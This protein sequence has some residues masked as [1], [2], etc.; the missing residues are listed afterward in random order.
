MLLI[1]FLYLTCLK[2]DKYSSILFIHFAKCEHFQEFLFD[3]LGDETS[4]KVST[5]D[6]KNL[7]LE[8]NIFPKGVCVHL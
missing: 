7:F 3:S 5:F 8:E 2:T 1:Y 4:R 6:G